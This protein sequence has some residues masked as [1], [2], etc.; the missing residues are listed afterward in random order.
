M[1]HYWYCMAF[2]Q[3]KCRCKEVGKSMA[4]LRKCPFCGSADV[5]LIDLKPGDPQVSCWV[6]CVKCGATGPGSPYRDRAEINWN[7]RNS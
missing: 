4:D 1:K 7:D 6:E 5:K 3:I 2:G